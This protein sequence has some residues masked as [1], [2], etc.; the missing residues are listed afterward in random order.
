MADILD[1]FNDCIKNIDFQIIKSV[2]KHLKWTYGLDGYYPDTEYLKNTCKQLYDSTLATM[3]KEDMQRC[4]S[5]TGGFTIFL[6][7]YKNEK[8]QSVF[9]CR[10]MFSIQDWM[11]FS[12]QIQR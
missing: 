6:Y 3:L 5:S 12:D 4:Q 1:C 7:K 2:M 10:I 8:N 11:T 9:G